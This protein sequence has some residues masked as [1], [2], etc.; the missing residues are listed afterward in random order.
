MADSYDRD[1]YNCLVI[2]VLMGV[3]ASKAAR[4]YWSA[5]KDLS[6]QER[7]ST[8]KDEGRKKNDDIE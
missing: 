3:G 1:A 8:E 2:A 6:P 7:K 5:S 4:L